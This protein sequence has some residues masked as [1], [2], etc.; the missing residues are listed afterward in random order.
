MAQRYAMSVDVGGTFTDFVLFDIDSGRMEAFHKVLTDSERP[1]RAVVKGWSEILEKAGA[2]S[3]HVDYAV[4]STTI[5]TN[6]IVERRGVKTALLTTRGFRDVL[7]IGI[8]QIYDIYDLFAP[9]PE[10]LIPRELRREVDERV[11]RDGDV[12][13]A[14]DDAEVRVLVDELASDGVESIAVSLMHAYR[15]PDHERRI[16]EI[17]EAT[18]PEITVSISSRVA[19]LIGEYE[20]TSTVAADAYV[21]PLLRRYVLDLLEQLRGLGF[22]REL[23]MMLSSGGIATSAAAIEFPIRLLESGPAAGAFAASYYGNLTGHRHVLSL[24]MG[25]TTAKAC[26]IENGVPG[27][28]HM[29]EADRVH[30]FKPGSGLPIMA[31]TIDL[32]EIGA[33]GGSIAHLNDLGLLNV[34]PQSAESNPGPACYGLGGDQ[35]TVTDANVALGYL[36]P[37]YFLGGRMT[38]QPDRAKESIERYVA[39]RLHLDLLDSA[40]GIHSIVN[41]NMAQAARTHLI[42]R[43]RDPRDSA[44]VAFGG[45]GPA[46]AV[47]VARILGITEVIV[48]F[49]AGVASAIGALTAPMSLPFAR[50]Y[51]TPLN[52]CDWDAVSRLYDEMR[53]EAGRAFAGIGGEED[54]PLSIG[55]RHALHR[56]ISRT[57]D[58]FAAELRSRTETLAALK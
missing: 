25:G 6:A 21:K 49:G 40:W 7:E 48:P 4:H 57:A 35:P 34:G 16:A 54:C 5:V 11:T 20:R 32:I 33:G 14:L 26:L 9:Y 29:L 45:A 10:P 50:S 19:P 47:E 55:G 17:F 28:A 12:V 56:S 42:E 31:P 51:M 3:D 53:D 30:R 43:N 18:H 58:R 44:V 22:T 46:H 37:G 23:Y 41:E 24:D 36:D 38:L 13:T 15:N 52:A 27:V 2:D 39:D 8:E 1:A